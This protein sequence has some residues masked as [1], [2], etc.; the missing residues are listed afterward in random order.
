MIIVGLTG[1]IASG[2][3]TVS[4]RL[5]E[6]H[7]LTIVDAD[8]IA[9]DIVQPGEP[10]YNDIVSYFGPKISNLVLEGGSL[11]RTALGKHVF[12]DKSEL[13]VLN[14]FTHPR[15]RKAMFWGVVKAYFSLQ[16]AVVLDVPLLFES[17]LD[18]FCGINICVLC[19]SKTQLS[20][21]QARNPDL[22]LEDCKNRIANQMSNE[23]RIKRA[24]IILDNNSSLE[25]LYLK[26]DKTVNNI[27]PSY[28]KTVLQLVIFPYGILCGI[29]SYLFKTNRQAQS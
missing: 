12:E 5:K 24:D 26:L 4:T 25:E 29:S 18:R 11:N 16:R 14:G 3:S 21:L 19:D 9:R 17:K 7:H 20:R 1:G 13:H 23:E 28:I 8:K 15:V 27:V 6:Y 10:A 22:S 2:K